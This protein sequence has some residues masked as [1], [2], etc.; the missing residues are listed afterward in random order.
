MVTGLEGEKVEISKE[1]WP[2]LV[3]ELKTFEAEELVDDE[4]EFPDSSLMRAYCCFGTYT[5]TDS[6]VAAIGNA[7]K[8]SSAPSIASNG[9]RK[10]ANR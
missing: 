5:L 7:R 6:V 9:K 8:H 4:L 2:E 3:G 1:L 10:G